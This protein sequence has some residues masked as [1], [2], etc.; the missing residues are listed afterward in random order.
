M[1]YIKYLHIFDKPPRIQPIFYKRTPVEDKLKQ[2]EALL[3]KKR[4]DEAENCFLEILKEEPNN[5]AAYKHLGVIASYNQNTEKAIEYF[6]KSLGI[7][8][9][10]KDAV[11]SYSKLLKKTNQ[12]QLAIPFL[13]NIVLIYPTDKKLN[14]LLEEANAVNSFS[15]R[16]TNSISEASNF[17]KNEAEKGAERSYRNA[18]DIDTDNLETLCALRQPLQKKNRIGESSQFLKKCI[19]TGP[20]FEKAVTMFAGRGSSPHMT[21]IGKIKKPQSFLQNSSKTSSV[22]GRDLYQERDLI[23]PAALSDRLKIGKNSFVSPYAIIEQPENI[24][25]GDNVQIKPGVVLRP[26]TG[27]ITIGN[28]VVINHYT[29]IHAKGGV[30]IGDW[31]VIA[32][33]CGIYAQNHLHD[34]FDIP[35]TKQP[36][37]GIGITLM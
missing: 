16:H 32:P 3:A 12:L 22:N 24:F 6:T 19:E 31:C 17:P 25:I 9:F 23:T 30:E 7:D 2:G 8:P 4:I 18:L 26:E 1:A 10:Y 11:L 34:S 37:I 14:D 13:S 15:E 29:V 28:N 27:Q 36:N 20:H 21:E 33:H 35:I 5:E